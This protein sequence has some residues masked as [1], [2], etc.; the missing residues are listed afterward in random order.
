MVI[1]FKVIE[2]AFD[3][4]SFAQMCEH[5]AFLDKESGKIYWHSE[6]GDNEEELPEDLEN[7]KYIEIPH[8]K[9]LGLGKDLVLDFAYEQLSNEANEIELIFRKKGAYSKFKA[10]LERKGVID[11]W[12]KYEEEAQEIAL[13]EWCKANEIKIKG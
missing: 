12:Y 10:F 1:E 4:V 7:E 2:E 11:K 13:R 9:E 8:K 5:Q 6:F 3:F